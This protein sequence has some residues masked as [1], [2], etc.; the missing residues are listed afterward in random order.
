MLGQPGGKLVEVLGQLNLAPQRPERL[1]EGT[2]ASQRHQPG[3]GPSGALN[4]DLLTPLDKVNQP[5]QLALRLVHSDANHDHDSTEYLART[6][7][8]WASHEHDVDAVQALEVAVARKECHDLGLKK[9]GYECAGLR[10]LWLVD[11]AADEVIVF[12]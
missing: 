2:T 5:R 3:D 11:T 7:P 8:T 4:D 9:S 1:R 12:R 6:D 10:E